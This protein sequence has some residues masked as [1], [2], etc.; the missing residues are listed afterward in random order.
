MPGDWWPIGAGRRL[1]I[2]QSL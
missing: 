1:R 2:R